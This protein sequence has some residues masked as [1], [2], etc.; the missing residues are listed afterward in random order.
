MTIWENYER[1]LD[2]NFPT[3]PCRER[4]LPQRK[5]NL[6][7]ITTATNAASKNCTGCDMPFCTVVL[8]HG[9]QKKLPIRSKTWGFIHGDEIFLR[10]LVLVRQCASR[11][12]CRSVAGFS[13]C[14]ASFGA[15][16]GVGA[17]RGRWD[18]EPEYSFHAEAAPWKKPTEEEQ[19][20]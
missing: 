20:H 19:T 18:S 6:V 1:C 9:H 10:V 7:Q 4:D 3:V 14:G 2:S 12:V 5:T 11:F 15:L 16:G 17:Q 8:T 13:G